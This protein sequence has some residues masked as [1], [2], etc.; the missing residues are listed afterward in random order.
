MTDSTDYHDY[1]SKDGKSIGDFE[2][3]YRNSDTTPWHQNDLNDLA[4]M[5]IAGFSIAP[6]DSHPLILNQ[7]NLVLPRKGGNGFVRE[8]IEMLIGL[9]RMSATEISN[10]L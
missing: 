6:V 4:A 2:S 9:E 8:F 1:V 10:L 5:Q 7:A 3:M